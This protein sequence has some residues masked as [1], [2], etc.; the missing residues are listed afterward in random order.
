[1]NERIQ[2]LK[3]QSLDA[4]N[5]ISSERAGLLTDFYLSSEAQQSSTPVMRAQ[6]LK[7]ILAHK[8]LYID[9]KEL[10]VGER[11]PEPKATPTF[12]EICLH[13]LND[14]D[15]LNNRDKVSF[16]VDEETKNVYREKI[17]PFWQGK[18][19]RDHIFRAMDQEWLNAYQAGVFTEFQ[20]QRAPGHTVAGGA[21]FQKGMLDLKFEINQAVQKL[22]YFNDP[23]AVD[24]LEELKAMDI[25]ADAIILSR[26][27]C[28]KP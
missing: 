16:L 22:D 25:A 10:I 19:Q 21:V 11:G 12:P 4:V 13:S 3:Q 15:T 27:A 17:I 28:T 6:A 26:P 23:L 20:E 7:H 2:K 24:K 8:S 14:L 9:D 5:R 18:T 1:M